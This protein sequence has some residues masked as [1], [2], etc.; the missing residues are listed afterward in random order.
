MPDPLSPKT[1]NLTV[2][3]SNT[4]IGGG[5][6]AFFKRIFD[7][8]LLNHK[9]RKQ[10]PNIP[11]TKLGWNLKEHYKGFTGNLA[12][13]IPITIFQ[14]FSKQQLTEYFHD[15][16]AENIS[17]RVKISAAAGAGFLG[18]ILSNPIEMISGRL[19]KKPKSILKLFPLSGKVYYN[20]THK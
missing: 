19:H 13:I 18:A 4:I 6:G 2:S 5:I 10:D 12:S 17:D 14:L 9:F 1:E 11:N 7:M 20:K 15:P 3:L 16:L 8:P